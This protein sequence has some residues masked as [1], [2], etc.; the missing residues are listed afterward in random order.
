MLENAKCSA[1]IHF[2]SRLLIGVWDHVIISIKTRYLYKLGVVSQSQCIS[3]LTI[4]NS[5]EN[6]HSVCTLFHHAPHRHLFAHCL[7]FETPTSPASQL[8]EKP[9]LWQ[10]NALPEHRLQRPA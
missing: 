6:N 9:S 2:K 5:R 8:S 10:R 7:S 4:L 1:D 3:K